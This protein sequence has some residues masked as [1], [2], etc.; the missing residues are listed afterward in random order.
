MMDREVLAKHFAAEIEHIAKQIT[1]A[2]NF[3]EI[4]TLTKAQGRVVNN[5]LQCGLIE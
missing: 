4:A 5:A 2:T 1:E 3:L